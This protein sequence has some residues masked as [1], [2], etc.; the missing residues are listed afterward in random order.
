[1]PAVYSWQSSGTELLMSSEEAWCCWKIPPLWPVQQEGRKSTHKSF[2]LLR[3]HLQ[4]VRT[5]EEMQV[6]TAVPFL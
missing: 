3:F 6:A 1:M 2:S 5:Q 4:Q